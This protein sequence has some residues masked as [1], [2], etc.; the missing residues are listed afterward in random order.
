MLFSNKSHLWY[1]R[2]KQIYL[3]IYIQITNSITNVYCF[4]YYLLVLIIVIVIIF[5][6]KLFVAESQTLYSVSHYIFSTFSKE[7]NSFSQ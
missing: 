2:S 6:L 4:I 5:I 7:V 3:Q 1:H